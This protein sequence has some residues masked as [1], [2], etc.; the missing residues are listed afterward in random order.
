VTLTLDTN[1]TPEDAQVVRQGLSAFNAAHAGDD[2]Y[3]RIVFIVRDDA[4]AIRGGLLGGTYWGW[5]SVDI[6]WLDESLR[7]QGW[8]TRLMALAED[9]ARQRGC[10]SAHLDTMDWQALDFYL[11]L[12][13][14]V[15]GQLDDLPTGH[16]RYFLKKS[17]LSQA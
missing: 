12:G 13:Y 9:E 1:G 11:K 15:W 6:L 5:L 10:H 3:Q 2:H 4:G 7:G 8:G 17:L 14:S 16:T